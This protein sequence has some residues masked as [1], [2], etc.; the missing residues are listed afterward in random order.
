MIPWW[1]HLLSY[2]KEI[3]IE[4][5]SSPHNP[6]LLVTLKR[7]RYRLLTENAIY[8]YDDLYDNFKTALKAIHIQ[9]RN[10]QEVLVLGLGLG[11]IP[12]ILE[13]TFHKKCYITAVELDEEVVRLATQYTLKRLQY[14]FDIICADAALFIQITE[15][16]YELICVDVFND[17]KI[18]SEFYDQEVLDHLK[19]ILSD[20]GILLFNMIGTNAEDIELASNYFNHHFMST[21]PQAEIIRTKHNFMLLNNIKF[22]HYIQ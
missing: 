3:Q 14:P 21:F 8:S 6:L 10:I 22:L 12:Y 11:S 19:N 18:P 5:S 13:K 1:K 7:G 9:D 16:K 2:F 15:Q 17:D 20:Q 4:H